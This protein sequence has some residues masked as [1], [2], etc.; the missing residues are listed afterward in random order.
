MTRNAISVW[1]AT[2]E[3]VG[4][5]ECPSWMSEPA[6]A[7]LLFG[8]VCQVCRLASFAPICLIDVQNFLLV[9]WRKEYSK[10]GFS[11]D[12]KSVREM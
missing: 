4:I 3:R 11:F 5:P 7:V 9:L 10:G 6:W 2:R 8:N 12:E 1:K